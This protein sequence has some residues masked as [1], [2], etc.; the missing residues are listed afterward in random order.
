MEKTFFANLS[1]ISLQYGRTLGLMLA[2]VAGILIPQA[3]VFSGL[4]EY[5]VFGMMFLSFVGLKFERSALRPS[6]L[7]VLV[8]N[9]CVA[10]TAFFM[11]RRVD[12]TLALVG[13]MTGISP[14][15]ISAPVVMALLE[16]RV[17]YVVAAVLLTNIG[18]ALIVPFLLPWLGGNQVHV[19]MWEV[20]WS[21]ALVVILP[22]ILA[23]L[24]RFLPQPAQ[25]SFYR[26]KGFTFIL[27]IS[28]LFLIVSKASHFIHNNVSVSLTFLGQIALISF[29]LCVINFSLGALLSGR[30]FR[31]ETSQVLG[32]KNLSFT[33]WLAL[34][35]INPIV[36]LGPTFYIIFHHTYNSFQL[37]RFAKKKTESHL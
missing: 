16:R 4:I 10:L 1:K 24:V 12:S 15:A 5:M 2:I 11:L 35:F 17:D 7:A 25:K 13:F 32:Q 19:S 8:A 18:M 21:V 33:I 26:A 27:W 37:Y 31:R 22:L 14:T 29:I 23:R 34:T 30:E 20:L 36:A 28:S 9:V 3:A 6:L